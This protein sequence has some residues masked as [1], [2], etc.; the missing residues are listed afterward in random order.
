VVETLPLTTGQAK[1]VTGSTVFALH[2][3]IAK[4]AV[5]AGLKKM[6]DALWL[7]NTGGVGWLS[8]CV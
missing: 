3:T 2:L 5:E 8:S 7:I 1:K 6:S 4:S